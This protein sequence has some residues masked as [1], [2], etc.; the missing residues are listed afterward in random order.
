MGI[1][2]TRGCSSSENVIIS[3]PLK[4][5]TIFDK[6]GGVSS[7]KVFF[8]RFKGGIVSQSKARK[9]MQEEE[10][11]KRKKEK[12][13]IIVESDNYDED[14]DWAEYSLLKEEIAI[15]EKRQKLE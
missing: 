13:G 3:S 5:F 1:L 7:R 11:R 2:L 12:E 6:K 15:R 4:T 9:E 8:E 10:T 14:G